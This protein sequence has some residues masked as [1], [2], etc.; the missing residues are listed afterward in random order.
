MG[1]FRQ[2]QVAWSFLLV[3]T[4]HGVQAVLSPVV[5]SKLWP[6]RT[7]SPCPNADS[8]SS[9]GRCVE[10]LCYGR[11]ICTDAV[12]SGKHFSV[13]SRIHLGD[14]NVQA[15]GSRSVRPQTSSLSPHTVSQTGA[16]PLL[17]TLL[18][19]SFLDSFLLSPTTFNLY[20]FFRL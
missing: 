10:L 6:L 8:E 4:A 2:L 12:F 15:V 3:G 1:S 16:F 17:T 9:V 14:G 7:S 5:R 13:L 19:E 20:F 11:L 18:K